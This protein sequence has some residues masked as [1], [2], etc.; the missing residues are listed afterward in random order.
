MSNKLTP[1]GISV[2]P[3]DMQYP[4]QSGPVHSF[5]VVTVHAGGQTAHLGHGGAYTILMGYSHLQ[6]YID[7]LAQETLNVLVYWQ[8]QEHR[9][10]VDM[11]ND[12]QRTA[13]MLE[14]AK[15]LPIYQKLM[16]LRE[17]MTPLI[18]EIQ[19]DLRNQGEAL[20]AKEAAEDLPKNGQSHELSDGSLGETSNGQPH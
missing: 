20:L 2:L 14:E 19:R 17:T 5:S 4:Q 9:V 10:I 1:P 7:L 8:K 18:E 11:A 16:T 15:A 13:Q 6:A 3:I 12:A